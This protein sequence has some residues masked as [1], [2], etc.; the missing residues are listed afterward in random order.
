MIHI[1][2]LDTTPRKSDAILCS[3]L[4]WTRQLFL[5]TTQIQSYKVRDSIVNSRKLFL[6]QKHNFYLEERTDNKYTLVSRLWSLLDIFRT[7][8]KI[9]LKIEVN[10]K[11]PYE[12]IREKLLNYKLLMNVFHSRFT[13]RFLFYAL[14]L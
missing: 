4:P 5:K 9:Q 6:L 10:R 12:S 11:L 3:I 8:N 14:Y 13:S 7:K 2:F 1:F